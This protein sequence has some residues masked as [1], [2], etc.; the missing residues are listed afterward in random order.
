MQLCLNDVTPLALCVPSSERRSMM[1]RV[2][3]VFGP[4]PSP[5]SLLPVPPL[6]A[7]VCVV[8]AVAPPCGA[9]GLRADMPQHL[10]PLHH[11]V[12]V[13][14]CVCVRVHVRACVRACT[15]ACMRACMRAV[16]PP[17]GACRPMF[18]S[19][20]CGRDAAMCFCPATPVPPLTFAFVGVLLQAAAAFC[21]CVSC[22]PLA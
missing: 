10:L 2:E 4:P 5:P 16:V 1:V 17:C 13:P 9:P 21:G 19:P 12:R 22:C 15:R 18:G 20:A 7:G 3:G 6:A 8:D 11:L 14:V